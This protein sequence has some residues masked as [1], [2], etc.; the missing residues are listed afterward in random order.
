VITGFIPGLAGDYNIDIGFVG[1]PP[2][3]LEAYLVQTDFRYGEEWRP[4]FKVSNSTVMGTMNI[5]PMLA[6]EW[7]ADEAEKLNNP[8]VSGPDAN[9]NPGI[10]EDT[11]FIGWTESTKQTTRYVDATKKPVIGILYK[12]GEEDVDGTRLTVPRSLVPAY[13]LRQG[14]FGAQAVFA[15]EGYAVGALNVKLKKYV[16]AVQPVY[17]KLKA[18]GRLDPADSYLERWIGQQESGEKDAKL[19]G[20][21]RTVIGLSTRGAGAIHCASLVVD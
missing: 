20:D 10:G 8:P 3:D 11:P 5:P 16:V 18:D 2:K 17:M 13:H 14:R 21:G 1:G 15:K 12:V 6:R 7:K 4:R 9:R 19:G